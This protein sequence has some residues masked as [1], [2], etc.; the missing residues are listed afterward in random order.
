M[1][2]TLEQSRIRPVF[3]F[4]LTA[5]CSL[6][7]LSGC[8]VFDRGDAGTPPS[9]QCGEADETFANDVYPILRARCVACHAPGLPG[10][11]TAFVLSTDA[12]GDYPVVRALVTPE[13]PGDSVLLKKASGQTSHGGGAILTE[14]SEE[15]G[16]LKSWISKGACPL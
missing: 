5:C 12:S 16:R 11:A 6:L 10:G 15:Y 14:S 9:P 4:L 7:T 8:G 1:G 3:R 2:I 13:K